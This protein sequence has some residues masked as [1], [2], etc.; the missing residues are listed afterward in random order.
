MESLYLLKKMEEF[1]QLE[2]DTKLPLTSEGIAFTEAKD[3]GFLVA[4]MI[5]EV[6]GADK[7]KLL[8]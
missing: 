8:L 5:K 4:A 6:F 1:F 2:R 3:G 7:N